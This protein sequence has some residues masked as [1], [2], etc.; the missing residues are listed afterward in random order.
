MAHTTNDP[1]LL[2]P[3]HHADHPGFSGI[4]GWVAAMS[5][6]V[7][8][9]GDADLAISLTRLAA[10]ERVVDIG[11][12]PGVA[13]RHAAEV[14]AIVTG[15]DPAGVML[16]VAR[17][18]DRHG[19]VTWLE[20]GAE[21]LPLPDHSCDVAWSLSTVHHWRDLDR[22]LAEVRRVL[23]PGGRFLA[24]ERRLKPGGTGLASHGWTDQQA[25]TFAEL[26]TS[27]G[28][29]GVEVTRHDTKRGVLQAL[30]AT[31]GASN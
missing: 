31:R 26:C 23:T 2:P 16:G 9:S 28:F 10:G 12:G 11:C 8:R 24:T 19:A 4:A 17:K 7:G 3:N 30:L 25:D 27:A 21:A 18:D 1:T 15:V 5:F 6:R 13:A 14:G 29:V 22:G 20:G